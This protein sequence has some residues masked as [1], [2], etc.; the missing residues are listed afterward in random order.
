MN[1]IFYKYFVLNFIINIFYFT[2][3]INAINFN[4]Q[5]NCNYPIDIYSHENRQ[6]INK[7]KL[8]QNDNCIV[9]YNQLESGLIKTSLSEKATLFEFTVNNKGIWYDISV[10]PPGS[11]VCYSYSECRTKSNKSGFNI[12]LDVNINKPTSSCVNLK[13]DNE[14][15]SDAY[16]YP[17]DDIKTKFCNL[18]TEFNLIYCNQNSNSTNNNIVI[19]N[20]I[21][22]CN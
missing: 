5:N 7:C 14:Q 13:C 19:E 3:S 9:S 22:E 20:N 6:F 16:L 10:I 11:G 8:N 18:E 17:Y 4:I 2:N 15:C 21:D 12:G 1:L